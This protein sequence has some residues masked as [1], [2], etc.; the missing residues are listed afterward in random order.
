[1]G[2][3]VQFQAFVRSFL[4]NRTTAI[5][6]EQIRTSVYG[7]GAG[8]PPPPPRPYTSVQASHPCSSTYLCE[9]FQTG[10]A[11]SG[12]QVIHSTQMTSRFRVQE[13]NWRLALQAALNDTEAYLVDT[14]LNLSPSKSEPLLE[15]LARQ[16]GKTKNM[17]RL[18]ARVSDQ[19]RGVCEDNLF[20]MYHVFLPS[21][22]NCTASALVWTVNFQ[23]GRE[24]ETID[25]EGE[26]T[27]SW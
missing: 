9:V 16:V 23:P 3:G 12:A 24:G 21:H 11:A 26:V 7:L 20:W 13:R 14:G 1:M 19:K 22:I 8:V 4:T 15:R 2:L 27:L 18:T 25:R 10:W 6:V 5:Q 17:L